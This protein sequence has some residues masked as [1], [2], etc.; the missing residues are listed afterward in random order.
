MVSCILKRAS[1]S[2]C[3]SCISFDCFSAL[4]LAVDVAYTFRHVLRI[5]PRRKMDVMILVF[6]SDPLISI[7]R[8]PTLEMPVL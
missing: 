5:E 6:L 2:L 8:F 4:N 1:T 3:A 7:K